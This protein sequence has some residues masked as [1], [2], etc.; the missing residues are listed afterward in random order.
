MKNIF[1]PANEIV[2]LCMVGMSLEEKGRKEDAADFFMRAWEESQNDFERFLAAF[3]V[4]HIQKNN[5]DKLKWLKKS[6]TCALNTEDASVR[7]AYRMLY[8]SIAACYEEMNDLEYADESRKQAEF[9]EG[10]IT[11]EGPFF[12]GTKAD[13]AAGDMLT[14]GGDSNYKPELKMNH[15][16]FTANINGAVLAAT[17]AKG[18]GAER[19]YVVEPTGNFENDPNVTD[20]RFP[21]NLT[22]SYRS[23]EPL[24]IVG[25]VHGWESMT[26]DEKR[27]WMEKLERNKGTIIN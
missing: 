12:H 19:I 6:L 1:N 18:E 4:G 20:K 5:E 15:I 3:H 16:Y 14:A 8:S 2:R 27:Q 25:E 13:L 21:G 26:K 9:Y 17:L 7:S 11:D 22:R 10:S 24:R 23:A